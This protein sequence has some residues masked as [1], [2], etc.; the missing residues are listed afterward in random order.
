M[1]P[2]NLNVKSSNTGSGDG[3]DVALTELWILHVLQMMLI[4]S[5]EHPGSLR[6]GGIF[7]DEDVGGAFAVF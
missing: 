1:L 2:V 3:L 4:F 6:Y 5:A 7:G